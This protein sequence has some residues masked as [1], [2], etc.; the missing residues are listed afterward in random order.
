VTPRD[1]PH[2][3]HVRVRYGEV[4][5]MGFVYHAHYLVF[6]EQGRTEY[7]RSL[8]GTY[9]H[10]EDAGTLLVVVET[11]VRHLKPA[12][13]DDLLTIRTWLEEARGVRLR[14]RY[15][16][17]RKGDVLA[18]GFTVLAAT[19]VAGRPRRLPDD[20]RRALEGA[21]GASGA[22]RKEGPPPA[23][24]HGEPPGA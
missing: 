4:D 2:E 18:T 7:L 11:G 12:T 3:T 14:F 1:D 15:E 19:D 16:V 20:F 13:Y 24:Q 22:E 17:A 8:G 6:F 21:A 5:R 23:V 10:V 9:R